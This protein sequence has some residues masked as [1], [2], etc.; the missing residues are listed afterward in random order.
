MGLCH[1]PHA[2]IP[3]MS[4]TLVNLGLRHPM[5]RKRDQDLGPLDTSHPQ[6]DCFPEKEVTEDLRPWPLEEVLGL[7][8]LQG[9]CF[10]REG[11]PWEGRSSGQTLPGAAGLGR[12]GPSLSRRMVGRTDGQTDGFWGRDSDLA[13]WERASS[14]QVEGPG[15]AQPGQWQWPSTPHPPLGLSGSSLRPARTGK[16]TAPCR[17]PFKTSVPAGE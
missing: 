8:R 15:E 7:D 6:R 3:C 10:C 5:V 12:G 13:P 16:G 17:A 14:G 4:L 9:G 11:T 2:P 1:R